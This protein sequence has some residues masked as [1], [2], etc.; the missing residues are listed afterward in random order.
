MSF[1]YNGCLGTSGVIF[2][3]SRLKIAYYILVRVSGPLQAFILAALCF[4]WTLPMWSS[5]PFVYPP[6]V[7]ACPVVD[8]THILSMTDA[9]S[10]LTFK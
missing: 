4:C 9:N 10:S 2:V 1:I 3:H 6:S 7:I 8:F 5:A